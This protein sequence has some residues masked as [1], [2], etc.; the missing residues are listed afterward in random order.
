MPCAA[1]LKPLKSA[2]SFRRINRRIVSLEDWVYPGLHEHGMGKRPLCE[3][4]FARGLGLPRFARTRQLWAEG[5]NPVGVG[6]RTYCV[7]RV[8]FANPGLDY[9]TTLWLSR[10]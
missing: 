3:P 9:A 4:G 6:G 7:P 8:G 5:R 2:A 1:G 10:R